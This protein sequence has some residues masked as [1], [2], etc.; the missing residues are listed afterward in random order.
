MEIPQ[1]VLDP[2]GKFPEEGIDRET[3]RETLSKLPRETRVLGTY[4]SAHELGKDNPA[5]LKRQKRA[6]SYFKETFPDARYA[7]LHPAPRLGSQSDVQKVVD[8]YAELALYA[9]TL[10]EDFQLCFHNHFDSSGESADQVRAYLEC[11]ETVGSPALNWGADIAHCHGMGEQYLDVFEAY[12]HLIGDFFHIKARIPAFDQ[13]HGGD[14]YRE[15]RDIWSNPAEI[16]KGLYSG[17]VN[18]ADP[19]VQTPFVEVFQF[20]R[21]KARPTNDVVRGALEIDVPRQH[22]RLEVLCAT[23]FLKNAHGV[24]TTLSLSNDEIISRVFPPAA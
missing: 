24:Q 4:L 1:N 17:F 6:L 19:E 13:L 14:A 10:S 18:V 15:D 7:M 8:A 22:P 12:V 20:I 2:N 16:G 9:Q 11:I 23:L 3:V 21:E 5:Y